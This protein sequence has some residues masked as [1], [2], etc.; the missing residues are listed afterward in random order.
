MVRKIRVSV[1]IY[2][3]QPAVE[4]VD[5]PD[6]WDEMSPQ[7]QEAELVTVAKD[8]LFQAAG[9]GASVVEVDS[10][11]PDVGGAAC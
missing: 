2:D 4:Y 5:L 10:T 8:Y 1:E 3:H 11:H 7:E 9:S 6:N